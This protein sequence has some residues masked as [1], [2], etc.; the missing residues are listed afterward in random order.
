M[1]I[2]LSTGTRNQLV[3]G[4]GFAR[5]F[6]RGSIEIYTGSQPVSADS[7][8][9]GTLLGVVTLGSGALTKETP[10]TG[11]ITITGFGG[12]INTIT[13]GGLN[14]IPDGAVVSTV[15]TTQTASDLRDAINRNGIMQASSSANVVTITAP[16]G[17]GAAWNAYAV[18]GSLATATAT[19]S[20]M[21]G[22]V[23]SVNGLVFGQ[24]SA[25]VIGKATGAT[26]G[27]NGIAAGTAGW[28]R[29]VASAADAGALNTAAPFLARLDGSIATSG[30]DLNLSNIVVAIGAPNTIDSF[31]WTQPTN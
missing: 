1:T 29:L 28:F 23:A 26:W 12:T 20:N 9:T 15:S 19:Y 22:G 4:A 14:I 5:I 7:A 24:P 3:Q 11:A 27:F 18:T 6:N 21:A 17:V 16:A 13:V 8:V 2:R 25:G 10:A 31:T 30:A